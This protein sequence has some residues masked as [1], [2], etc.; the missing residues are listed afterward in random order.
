M[1]TLRISALALLVGCAGD[2]GTDTDTDTDGTTASCTDDPLT[3]ELGTGELVF[4]ALVEGGDVQMVHGPQ[5]G[6]HVDVAG[7]VGGSSQEVSILPSLVIP[8]Q[9]DLQVAG[10]QQPEFVAL[11]S[12][13]DATCA[14]E[15]FGVRAFLDDV[16]TPP[17]G[18]TYQEFICSLAG[19]ATLEVTVEDIANGDSVTESIGVTLLA[20]PSDGC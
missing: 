18:L 2:S 15:Y 7:L 1:T 17:G 20:D 4:E 13:D 19:A 12:Y 10:D 8:G 9:G 6:W 3:L 11:A 5:G 16:A 14:G